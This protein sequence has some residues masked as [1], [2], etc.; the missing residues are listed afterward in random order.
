MNNKLSFDLYLDFLRSNEGSL[1]AANGSQ[2]DIDSSGGKKA[3]GN[4]G[5]AVSFQFNDAI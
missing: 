1:A 3:K 2:D 4:N 5:Q